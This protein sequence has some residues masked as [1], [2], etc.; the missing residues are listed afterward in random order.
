MT[1]AVVA[2]VAG[3]VLGV[4]LFADWYGADLSGA[5]DRVQA[6]VKRL[7]LDTKIDAWQAFGVLDVLLAAAA[8][9]GIAL[10]FAASVPALRRYVFAAA[11]LTSTL[12][13]AG[14]LRCL[15]RVIDPPGSSATREIGAFIGLGAAIVLCAAGNVAVRSA[16]RSQR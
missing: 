8:V 4:S 3:G 1:S 12:A 5:P 11:A 16:S 9:A 7:N 10:F 6:I 15:F 14:A 2:G 13:T